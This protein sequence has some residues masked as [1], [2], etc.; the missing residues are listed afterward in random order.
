[1]TTELDLARLLDVR[2]ER[3]EQIVVLLCE[4]AAHGQVAPDRPFLAFVDDW[5]REHVVAET[6]VS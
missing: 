2:I 1:M 5:R 3:L 6:G 4:Q